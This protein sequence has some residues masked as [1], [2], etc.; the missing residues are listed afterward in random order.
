MY[1]QSIDTFAIVLNTEHVGG[2]ASE[3]RN[4][5]CE[6]RKNMRNRSVEL[7]R[8]GRMNFPD[9]VFLG[10]DG[11][12]GEPRFT[13][14]RGV[15]ISP[16]GISVRVNH[17]IPVRSYVSLRSESL[18]LSGNASVRYCIRRDGW[19]RLGLEFSSGIM[20]GKLNA[21]PI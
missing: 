21:S 7:R 14:A 4:E 8:T 18:N 9:R 19:Y 17:S 11:E 16:T 3:R 15:N 20:L 12:D 5:N 6:N 10:W 13:I 2:S 1:L